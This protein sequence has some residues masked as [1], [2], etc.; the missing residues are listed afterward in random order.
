MYYITWG[1]FRFFLGTYFYDFNILY[2]Y[3]ISIMSYL[4]MNICCFTTKFTFSK[5]NKAI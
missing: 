4:L 2:Y 3:Q 1:D 5:K